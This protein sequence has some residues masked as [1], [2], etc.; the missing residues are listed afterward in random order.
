LRHCGAGGG[1]KDQEK[2]CR[3]SANAVQDSSSIRGAGN[4]FD[5]IA[6]I[7][8]AAGDDRDTGASRSG[9]LPP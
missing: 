7:L 1:E 8:Q 6:D 9:M 2:A 5:A 3:A 4:L